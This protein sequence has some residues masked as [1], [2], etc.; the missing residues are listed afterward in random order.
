[1]KQEYNENFENGDI[2][3]C[4]VQT[5]SPKI[6]WQQKRYFYPTELIKNGLI[7]PNATDPVMPSYQTF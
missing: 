3:P 1:M 7:K 4:Y 5:I 6:Q 2:H